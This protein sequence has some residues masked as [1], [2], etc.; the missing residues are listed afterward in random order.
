MNSLG[1][2]LSITLSTVALGAVLV[3]CAPEEN[4]PPPIK[5][6]AVPLTNSFVGNDACKDCHTKAFEDH[7]RTGHA[8]TLLPATRSALASLAPPA[9]RIPGTDFAIVDD[10]D[11]LSFAATAPGGEKQKIG[12]V[13]GSGKYGMTYIAPVGSSSLIEFRLSYFPHEK[14]WHPTPGQEEMPDGVLG[15][16][17][18]GEFARKCISCHAVAVPN[19]SLEAEPKFQG[20]GCESCHGMGAKH[21]AAE[22][23]RDGASGRMEKLALVGGQR[24]NDLCATCHRGPNDVGAGSQQETMTQRFQPY[25]LSL[26]PCFQKS[27]DKLSCMT[28]HTPHDNVSRDHGFYESKCLGCHSPSSVV[29]P[30]TVAGKVCRVNPKSKCIECHMPNRKVFPNSK[31]PIAMADHLI[32]AARRRKR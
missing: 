17:H 9:G 32:W 31:V 28:C 6:S 23:A 30:T 13:L 18:E 26:S 8:S 25:G 1:P 16:S 19:D 10:G 15:H 11:K 14:Q 2:I 20:V 24:I 27:D 29:T 4:S 3:G 7:M 12:Y 21:V 5:T 22:R